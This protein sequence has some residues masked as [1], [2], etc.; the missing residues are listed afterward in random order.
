[1]GSPSVVGF[2]VTL[3]DGASGGIM[4]QLNKAAPRAAETDVKSFLEKVKSSSVAQPNGQ[5]RLVFAMDATMSRQPTW[6]RALSIQAQMFSETKRAGQL[7][8]QLVYFRGF[9]ECKA[10]KWVADADALARLMT[11]VECRGG[12]TQ[13]SRVLTH[14]KAEAAKAKPSAVVFVG[15][16]F[17]E[18]IDAV[19]QQAGEVGLLGI[20]VFM[21]QEG[22][23]A[24][25]ERA[26]REIAKLTHGAYFRLDGASPQVLAE[27]LGAVAAYATGGRQALASRAGNGKASHTLLQQLK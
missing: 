5:G 20:P 11:G 1:M 18:N 13:V 22:A 9:N 21:F 26:F 3:P 19:C 27:L 7:Q 17:E 12:N 6:D 10:S 16:A 25:A 2:E 8:V 14:V 4:N 15:D 23:D 24:T